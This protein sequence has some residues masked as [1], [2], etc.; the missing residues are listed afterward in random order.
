MSNLRLYLLGSPRLEHGGK[1]IKLP[2]AKSF[3]LLT[4]LAVTAR[5][6]SREKL[7]AL[8][9]P[10]A[11]G[12]QSRQALR[13]A[14]S[15]I[16]RALGD[17]HISADTETA[18]FHSGA[19]AWIDVAELESLAAD[20]RRAI[21]RV[22]HL[23]PFLD[24]FNLK[25]APE[26]DDWVSF[27]RARIHPLTLRTLSIRADTFEGSGAWG[28]AMAVARQLLEL[29][30]VR[31]ETH[32]QLMRLH[33]AMGDRA[34]ALQAYETARAILD[35]EL[36][37]EPM[38][39]TR[40]L[41]EQ[42]RDEAQALRTL[43]SK[44]RPVHHSADA[45]R[46]ELRLP[47]VGRKEERGQMH[48]AWQTVLSGH[49]QFVWVEGEA[50]VGKTR[51]IEQALGELE[52]EPLHPALILS[53]TSHPFE[54]N[55]PYHPFIDLARGYFG[56][57]SK[58]ISIPDI[59]MSE[60]TRL[61]PELR[62]GRTDLPAA[63][64]LQAGQERSRLDGAQQERSRLFEA[65]SQ[66][67][68]A[69]AE[70]RPL[71]LFFDDLQWADPSTLALLAFLSQSL[72]RARV[73]VVGAF[74]GGE[75]LP[76]FET[77][78]QTLSRAGL[79]VR[80]SMHRLEPDEVLELTRAISRRDYAP[81]AEWLY[82]ESEGNPFFIREWVTYMAASGYV[83]ADAKG[84]QT[85][86]RHLMS[87]LPGLPLPASIQDLVRAQLQR[88]SEGARQLLDAAA[89]IGREFDFATLWR[90]SS[91]D[92]DLALDGL[93]GLLSAQ[94]VR[95]STGASPYEFS[96]N[97]IR[98]V[99]LADMSLARQQILH[100][101]VGEALEITGHERLPELSG[102]LALHFRMGGEW[103]RAARYARA[104]G[105][106]ARAV[107][108][109]EEAIALYTSALES[110]SHIDDPEATA[111]LH[112]S[113]GEAY[114]VLG[115]PEHASESYAHALA[116]WEQI[117]DR[118]RAIQVRIE[119]GRFLI[120]RAAYRQAYEVA[121]ASLRELQTLDHPDK[122]II[123]QAHEGAGVALA[124]LGGPLE[125]AQAH[126]GQAGQ[127]FEQAKDHVGLCNV[128]FTLGSIAAQT[129]ELKKAIEYFK[130]AFANAELGGEIMWQAMAANNT[131]YHLLL[132]GDLV[133]AN[134]W[135]KRGLDIAESHRIT[136]MLLFLY[137]TSA[138]IRLIEKKWNEAEAD[139]TNGM[140]LAEQLGSPERRS[141]YFAHF[142]E[143][144]LGRGKYDEA[145]AKMTTA[146]QLAD[147]IG[148]NYAAARYHLRLAE[149]LTGGEQEAEARRHWQRGRQIA[150][151]G[152]FRGLF[153]KAKPNPP[154]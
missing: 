61:V 23:A 3:A 115:Q 6:Q 40:T 19:S 10:E 62:Q 89:V 140:A 93:D 45:Q 77:L 67:L 94:V 121:Q 151:K 125:E 79:L 138:E 122:R 51:L 25:D 81:F 142:A 16:R 145:L 97:K 148:P 58:P 1:P 126:L 47:F 63:L 59:W 60:L 13:T 114:Y 7:A 110:L 4:Y 55:Q 91:Q 127:L 22:L 83:S 135:L 73:L 41:F 136:P 53:G 95:H 100:R 42:I 117:G 43:Q 86:L 54:N 27:E 8:L 9:W 50:G 11:S 147:E 113:M 143:V 32:R 36:G 119:M 130:Q 57:V 15:D 65:I 35:R 21:P 101:R 66:F 28:A 37:V 17:D 12:S 39:E 123:A 129:G 52:S 78:T 144:A 104:A 24:G 75:T 30:P 124:F 134:V 49:S 18:S 139:A 68:L 116:S 88:L 29:D 92:E 31:E 76:V 99:V 5:E 20:P 146:V 131:A 109:A 108:A 111:R 69:L 118:E 26:F 98:E 120:L 44:S 74:R 80:V 72:A 64:R 71:A 128:Q 137:S 56:T 46:L 2:R 153:E 107:F 141:G 152:N 82:K 133:Q 84:W 85:D 105:D 87:T 34:A 70:D 150:E 112:Q 102:T 132:S 96:H 38:E 154:D 106:R 14:L 33:Y 103:A 90:A 149:M 48:R